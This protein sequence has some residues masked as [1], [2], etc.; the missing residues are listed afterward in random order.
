V[1]RRHR[2]IALPVGL[3]LIAWFVPSFSLLTVQAYP[4]SFVR[5][6]VAY[7]TDSIAQGGQLYVANC[8]S[9]HGVRAKGDGPAAADLTLAPADLTAAHVLDHTEGDIFWWLTAGIPQSGMPGFGD[10]MTENKR[11]DLVNWVRTMPVGGLDDGL[12]PEVGD[13]AAPRAP[14]FTFATASG[15]EDTLRNRLARGPLL[16]VLFTTP[17]SAPRL[18]QLAAAQ[19]TLAASGLDTLALPLGGDGNAT[20]PPEPGFVAR[21]DPSVAA[22]YRLI[23]TARL[24]H[25]PPPAPHL[26]FLIDRDGYIRALWQPGEV[27]G[28]Q[29]IATLI[30]Q[31]HL[32]AERKLAPVPM[33]MD[34]HMHM[35]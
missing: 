31:V 28:W 11:W 26:E 14:D 33:P 23:A 9:C 22:V 1:R 20:Q 12:T 13:E 6:A 21:A 27:G 2:L 19:G 5:S 24:D 25:E 34:M 7:T 15:V 17:N 30:R 35:G 16:L 32:L 8:T 29:D 3:A 4:T 10:R 18:A